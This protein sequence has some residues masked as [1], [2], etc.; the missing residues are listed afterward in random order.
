MLALLISM[1]SYIIFVVFAGTAAVRDA[2]GNITDVV[3]GTV[4]PCIE[5]CHW[6]L[7]NSYSVSAPY[8]RF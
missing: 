8:V 5:D 6:G 3:N 7:F 2:S 4:L 1:L